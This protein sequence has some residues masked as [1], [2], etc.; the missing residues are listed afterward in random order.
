MQHFPIALILFAP[1]GPVTLA[2]IH[3]AAVGHRFDWIGSAHQ[4]PLA[5]KIV[6]SLVATALGLILVGGP[7]MSCDHAD[8][9]PL[10]DSEPMRWCAIW[11]ILPLLALM[12]GSLLLHPMFQIRYIAPVTAGF[13]I[14]AA[15]AL[16][17]AGTRIRNLAAVAIASAFLVVAILFHL[18][19]QPFDLWRRIAGAVGALKSPSQAVFF[20]AGYVMGIRQAAERQCDEQAIHPRPSRD[21]QQKRIE[22]P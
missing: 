17:F 5:I 3:A 15:A 21:D 16:N 13:A 18:Y 7:P 1:I 19:H 20:E 10:D 11:S 12:V 14:L 8:A 4:T 2:Q 9:N 6:G 22:R